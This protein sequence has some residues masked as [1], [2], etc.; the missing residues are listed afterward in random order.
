MSDALCDAPGAPA[1]ASEAPVTPDL[2]LDD[3]SP[4]ALLDRVSAILTDSV[5]ASPS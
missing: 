3:T 1:A 5:A 4:E 2:M